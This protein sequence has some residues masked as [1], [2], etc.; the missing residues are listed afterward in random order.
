AEVEWAVILA[1]TASVFAE[2]YIQAPMQT[3]LDTPMTPHRLGE[4]LHRRRQA[5]RVVDELISLLAV[6]HPRAAHHADA[7]HVRPL[8]AG[9]YGGRR[10][11]DIVFPRLV[12]AVAAFDR[13]YTPPRRV[14]E[15]VLGVGHEGLMHRPVQPRLI[16]LDS[17]HIVGLA[18][19]DGGGDLLLAAHGVDGHE[20]A[21]E[22]K[23]LE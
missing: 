15:V 8:P 12:P 9:R 21:L 18:G 19:A 17:Q 20:A 7:A 13:L 23:Q 3:V 5:A 10:R 1:G 11:G 4:P 16:I 22:V 2:N 6:H 14:G